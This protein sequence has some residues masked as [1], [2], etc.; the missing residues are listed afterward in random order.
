[1]RLQRRI[2]DFSIID[3]QGKFQTDYGVMRIPRSNWE[4]AVRMDS[5]EELI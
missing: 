4:A 3:E 5:W 2:D 1:M